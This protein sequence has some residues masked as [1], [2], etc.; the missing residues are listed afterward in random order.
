MIPQHIAII[1]DGNGRWAKERGFPR[2]FGHREGI[3]RVKDIINEAQKIG[4]KVLTVFAFSTENWN[5]PKREI[6][7]LMGYLENYLKNNS[8]DFNKKGIQLRV[9]GRQDRIPEKLKKRIDIVSESTK[10]NS[11]FILNLALDYGGRYDILC[12]VKKIT[13][14][15]KKDSSFDVK[16]IDEE[17]FSRCLCTAGLPEPDLLIRTSGEERISNFML[18]QLSYSELYF[19]KKFWPDFRKSDLEEAIEVFNQ[20]QRRFGR[21]E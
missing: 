9:M 16:A 4:I 14:L 11:N 20:R 2:T 6:N 7:M 21:A 8:G 10:N 12:A 17:Y 13:S 3:Q 19:C 1:M 18:W 15:V 5:R